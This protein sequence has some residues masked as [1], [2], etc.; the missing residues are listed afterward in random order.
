MQGGAGGSPAGTPE[1]GEKR[2]A[3]EASVA[4]GDT[5]KTI[6]RHHLVDAAA[7]REHAEGCLKG[8]LRRTGGSED[9]LKAVAN[10]RAR[11]L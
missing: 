1:D 9:D 10:A 8:A 11:C 4:A 6:G 2:A 5:W 7:V 3:I